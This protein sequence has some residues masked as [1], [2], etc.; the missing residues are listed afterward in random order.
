MVQWRCAVLTEAV[1]QAESERVEKIGSTGSERA[2]AQQ[3]DPETVV[4]LVKEAV[5]DSPSRPR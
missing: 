3:A 5:S 2:R 4:R 1:R